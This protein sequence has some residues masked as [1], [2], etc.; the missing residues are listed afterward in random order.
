VC[1]TVLYETII[2]LLFVGVLNDYAVRNQAAVDCPFC[3]PF[4]FFVFDILFFQTL[5]REQL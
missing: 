4:A 2:I 1:F 3:V 5:L